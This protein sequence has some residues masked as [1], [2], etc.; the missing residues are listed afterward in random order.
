LRLPDEEVQVAMFRLS[1]QLTREAGYQQYEISNY[2]L[3]G[4]ACR[5]NL[6]YWHNRPYLGFGPGAVSFYEGRRWMNVKH[7]REYVRRVWAGEP[8]DIESEQLTGWH[9]VAETLMLGLRLI[10]GIDLAE[11]ERRYGLPVQAHYQPIIQ[12]QIVRGWLLQ[13]GTR[14]RLSDEG[15][16]WHSEVA[17]EFL[18]A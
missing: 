14:I 17:A 1:Q 6:I 2:A 10:E 18:L 12:S 5:H 9:A 15:L 13:E 8:L 4:Y 11:L 16:L 7:P 3:P